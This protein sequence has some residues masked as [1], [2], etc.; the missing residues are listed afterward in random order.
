MQ[1]PFSFVLFFLLFVSVSLYILL[2]LSFFYSLFLSLIFSLSYLSQGPQ[3]LILSLFLHILTLSFKGLKM[4]L[5]SLAM[6]TMGSM[7]V[8]PSVLAHDLAAHNTTIYG[9]LISLTSSQIDMTGE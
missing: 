2:L 8:Y 9:S 4:F 7:Y 6:W 3:D 1:F 5:C